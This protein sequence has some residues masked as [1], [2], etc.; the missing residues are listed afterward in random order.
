MERAVGGGTLFVIVDVCAWVRRR[1][2]CSLI[3]GFGNGYSVKQLE[4][5]SCVFLQFFVL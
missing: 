5:E 3:R 2:R 4:M 1:S